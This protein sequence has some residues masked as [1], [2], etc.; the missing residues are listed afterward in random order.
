[1]LF[2][3]KTIILQ[4]TNSLTYFLIDYKINSI[5]VLNSILKKELWSWPILKISI[6]FN[7]YN[8]FF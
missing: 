4:K 7:F 6:K 5:K 8:S 2:L 3:K 1:M